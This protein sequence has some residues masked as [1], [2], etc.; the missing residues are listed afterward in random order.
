MAVLLLS[1]EAYVVIVK[2]KTRRGIDS[3][4]IVERGADHGLRTRSGDAWRVRQ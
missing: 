2:A 1:L 4:L 3:T